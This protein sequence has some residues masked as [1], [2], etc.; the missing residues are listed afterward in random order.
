MADTDEKIGV[1]STLNAQIERARGIARMLDTAVRIP[2]TGIRFGLDSVLGLI[3]G[4]GDAAGA[5]FSGYLILL[6]SRMGLPRPVI[7]R[8]VANVA[9]DTIV[10]GIPVLGDLFDVAWKSN[11]R[12]LK[13]LEQSVDPAYEQP[14]VNKALVAVALLVLLLLVIGGLWLAVIAIRALFN[15]IS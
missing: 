9:I 10:G 3:P 8:M 6:G 13:L 11:T 15:A 12:N 5:L 1:S 7:T 2:G 14:R 4:M